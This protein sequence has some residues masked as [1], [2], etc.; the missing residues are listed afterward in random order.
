MKAIGIYDGESATGRN[1]VRILNCEDVEFIGSRW[2]CVGTFSRE[3]PLIVTF[4][5]QGEYC[6]IIPFHRVN[7][8]R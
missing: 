2:C 6:T 3:L 5:P 7:I 8:I 1:M 4:E